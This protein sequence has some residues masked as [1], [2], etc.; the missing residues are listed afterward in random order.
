MSR[1]LH[2]RCGPYHLL[3]DTTHVVEVVDAHARSTH[4][5]HCQWRDQTVR[6]LDLRLLL[7]AEPADESRHIICEQPDRDGE[8]SLLALTVDEA[9]GLDDYEDVSFQAFPPVSSVAARCFDGA[10]PDATSGQCRYRL[11]WPLPDV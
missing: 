9:V 11:R 6:V 3:L 5:S 8:N 2:C 4:E 7:K 10:V 1:Y